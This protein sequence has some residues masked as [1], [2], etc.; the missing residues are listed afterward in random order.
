MKIEIC[1]MFVM[2]VVSFGKTDAKATTLSGWDSD[3]SCGRAHIKPGNESCVVKCLRG[4][5]SVGHPE[6]VPQRMV[7]VSDDGKTTWIVGN[8]DTLINQAGRHV[9]VDARYDKH[10]KSVRILRLRSR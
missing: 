4:G 3:E 2:V 10:K 8:P 5:A 1:V 7:L 6:W 9:F